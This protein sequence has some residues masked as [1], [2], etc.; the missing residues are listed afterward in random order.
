MRKNNK[1]KAT[2]LLFIFAVGYF[3]SSAFRKNFYGGLVESMCEAALVGGIA[4]WFGVTAIFKKPLNIN[5]PKKIFRTNILKENK[6]KFISTIVDMVE[7]DLLN[8]EK[9]NTKIKNYDYISFIMSTKFLK[10]ENLE[11]VARKLNFNKLIKKKIFSNKHYLDKVLSEFVNSGYYDKTV[12]IFIDKTIEVLK[13]ENSIKFIGDIVNKSIDRYEKDSSGRKFAT[14]I[15]INTILKGNVKL[16]PYV[17]VDGIVQKLKIIKENK[18]KYREEVKKMLVSVYQNGEGGTL[19]IIL[20][21]IENCT[22]KCKE[23]SEDCKIKD[24]NILSK[25]ITRLINSLGKST[26]NQFIGK[27]LEKV[28]GYKHSEIG[29]IVKESLNKYND[30]EIINLAYD[31]A[32]DELQLIRINGSVV[33]GVLGVIIFVITKILI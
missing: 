20:E 29:K 31:K 14:K 1:Y 25:I 4:D 30:E 24:E 33:G 11:E 18:D 21:S 7:N 16:A 9:I 5:W 8:K 32:G 2:I 17:I 22:K 28:V 12:N 3:I 15:I 23:C 13:A 19:D 6:E 26:L 27:E 10:D